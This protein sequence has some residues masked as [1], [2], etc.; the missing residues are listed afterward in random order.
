MKSS[1]LFPNSLRELERLIKKNL[2]KKGEGPQT[3]IDDVK[4]FV[5]NV[6]RRMNDKAMFTKKKRTGESK[7]H[8][9]EQVKLKFADIIEVFKREDKEDIPIVFESSFA[10]PVNNKQ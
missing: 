1:K 5:E 7:E 3:N 2:V 10:F 9:K 8:A 4:G 6:I